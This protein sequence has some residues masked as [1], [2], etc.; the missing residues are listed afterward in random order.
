MSEQKREDLTINLWKHLWLE[1]WQWRLLVLICAMA[2]AFT[3][4]LSPYY[5]K[6]FVDALLSG[7]PIIT[8][9]LAA[10]FLGLLSQFLIQLNVWITFRE[11]LISQKKIGD[12]LYHRVLEGPGGFLA[13]RPVGEA[14]SLFAVDV[15]GAA[16]IIDQ[17]LSF[18]LSML[19]PILIAPLT[20]NALYGIPAVASWL[21]GMVTNGQLMNTLAGS[22]T[23]L[24]NIMAVLLLLNLRGAQTPPSAGELLSLLWIV[25]VFLSRP[26]RQLPWAL[27]IILDSLSSIR[28]LQNAF[29]VPLTLPQ[30]IAPNSPE[31]P[32][33]NT[34]LEVRD[35]NLN[36]QGRQLLSNIDLVVAPGE[37]VGIVGEVGSGKSM[38]LQSL[39]G[40]VGATFG[41][42]ALDGVNTTGPDSPEVRRR[43]AFVPQESIMISATLLENVEFEYNEPAR[44]NNQ[45]VHD[46]LRP[47]QFNPEEEHLHEGLM[48]EIGERGVNLSGGQRQRIGLARAHFTHRPIIIMDDCLSAVDVDTEKKILHHLLLGDW[49]LNTRLIATH[50]TAVLPHCDRILFLQEGK[51]AMQGTYQHLLAQSPAFRSFILKET[52]TGLVSTSTPESES[53]NDTSTPEEEMI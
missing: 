22:S 15:P 45:K 42:F 23:Y 29:N 11:S 24:L 43:M 53:L 1:R 31:R 41:R 5:Q 3:G 48:T 7:H 19:F 52:L 35:L 25:G 21:E 26:L 33:L 30:V 16:A 39:V 44:I 10:F 18:G 8:S 46:S 20:L 6:H 47:S 9:L 27:V 37:L 36:I 38:L 13:H 28:R 51:I 32:I 12:A 50:R 4:V 14:V 34:A 17:A 49:R 2:S 40:M